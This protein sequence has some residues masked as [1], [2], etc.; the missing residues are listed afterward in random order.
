MSH[1]SK[2]ND[3]LIHFRARIPSQVYDIWAIVPN[4][5]MALF[6]FMILEQDLELKPWMLFMCSGVLTSVALL[7]SLRA[8]GTATL[9]IFLGLVWSISFAIVIE[10]WTLHPTEIEC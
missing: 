7:G 6:F 2:L 10:I 3:L 1:I 8:I 5:L 4:L 9:C